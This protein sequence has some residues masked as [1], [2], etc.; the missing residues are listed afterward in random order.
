[1]P[2]GGRTLTVL[3]MVFPADQQ[4]SPGAEKQ[5]LHRLAAVLPKGAKPILV[6]DAGFR[7]PWFRAVEAMGW[8]WLGRL[9]NRTQLK[10]STAPDEA[11]EWVP[12]KA[13]YEQYMGKT[14][15]FG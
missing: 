10:P 12:C 11:D 4:G 7:G 15:D 13:M 14:R 1:M 2:V 8:H 6:T 9:R 3:D 5:F